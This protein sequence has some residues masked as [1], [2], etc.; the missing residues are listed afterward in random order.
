M[1]IFSYFTSIKP[2]IIA[3]KQ[4]DAF[5]KLIMLALMALSLI[6]WLVI[7]QKQKQFKLLSLQKKLIMDETLKLKNPLSPYEPKDAQNPFF[8]LYVNF[9]T[10][11]LDLLNKNKFFKQSENAA[12]YLSETDLAMVEQAA[13]LTITESLKDLEKNLSILSTITTLAPFLGL[14]GTVWGILMT[15]SE[16]SNGAQAAQNSAVIGG[17]SMALATTV[18][19][20]LIAIPSLIGFNHLRGSLKE[21]ETDMD[22]YLGKLIS[23]LELQYRKV[24]V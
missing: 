13:N 11:A 1:N 24:D 12:V 22:T 20:L 9:K 19:G 7:L 8:K 3:F 4:S 15:F 17:L 23:Q 6:C 5:G 10:K 18:M 21:T 2:F 16:L 14:L